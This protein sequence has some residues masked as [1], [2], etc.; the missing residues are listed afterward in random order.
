MQTE[1]SNYTKV[2]IYL[3]WLIAI[4]MMTMLFLGEDMIQHATATFYPSLHISLGV[5]ILVL[6]LVRLWWRISH[7]PPALPAT[8]KKWEVSLSSITHVI[9]YVLMI[10]LPLSGMMSFSTEAAKEVMLQGATVFG[11]LPAPSLPNIGGI[12]GA[13]HGLGAKLGQVLVILHVLAAL[14]HQFI[15]KDNLLKR[16]SPH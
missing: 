6:S 13:V 12:G 1:N 15:D 11:V 3:H 7:K 16:M 8:M 14:K 5:S 4:L 10:G 9:F 2:A